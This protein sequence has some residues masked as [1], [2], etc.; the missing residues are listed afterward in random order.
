MGEDRSTCSRAWPC[1][2][3]Q[4]SPTSTQLCLGVIHA[5]VLKEF[6]STLL[7]QPAD[8]C[9]FKGQIALSHFTTGWQQLQVGI[10]PVFILIRAKQMVGVVKLPP[11]KRLPPI[12][13]Y[14]DDVIGVLQIGMCKWCKYT[15]WADVIGQNPWSKPLS[16][17]LRR[18][19]RTNNTIFAGGENIP[20]CVWPTH[21]KPGK[22]CQTKTTSMLVLP[23]PEGYVAT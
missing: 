23:V 1:H 21:Q 9:P 20:F 16:L 11:Y 14:I 17:L 6:G 10:V 15:R 4:V 22:T 2:C 5:T 3:I 19:I 18:G 13:S 7:Q 8:K 12:K